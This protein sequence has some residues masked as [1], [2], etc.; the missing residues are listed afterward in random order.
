MGG[1]QTLL[2]TYSTLSYWVCRWLHW[3]GSYESRAPQGFPWLLLGHSLRDAHLGIA[4]SDA[5]RPLSGRVDDRVAAL[6][7]RYRPR[8]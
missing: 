5:G 2:Q 6:V 3:V 8:D 7:E 4:L 1:L